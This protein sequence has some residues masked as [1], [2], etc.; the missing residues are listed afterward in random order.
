MPVE[1]KE[2]RLNQTCIPG[3]R[4]MPKDR[5]ADQVFQDVG[6][7]HKEF[8]AMDESPRK[9]IRQLVK[10]VMDLQGQL[11]TFYASRK[12]ERDARIKS[13]KA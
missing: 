12:V 9:F 6:L 3:D 7:T 1:I 10:K 2:C 13:G 11:Q 8:E 5:S 4:E